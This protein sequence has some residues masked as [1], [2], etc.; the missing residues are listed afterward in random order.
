MPQGGDRVGTRRPPRGDVTRQ[1]SNCCQQRRDRKKRKRIARFNPIKQVYEVRE[2]A[3][4][5]NR[6]H[7][8]DH[9]A[10]ERQTQALPDYHSKD[11]L[12]FGAKRHPDPNLVCTLRN[13]I[14]NHT[15]NSDGR[16]KQR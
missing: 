10:G 13:G 6:R 16:Q 2:H 12:L 8:S 9:E 11:T 4:E 5:G 7:Y 15:L 1:D 14:G 3:S